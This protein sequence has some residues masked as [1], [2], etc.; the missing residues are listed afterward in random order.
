MSTRK[1]RTQLRLPGQ[2]PG[3]THELTVLRWRGK[4]G[5]PR[6]Y[7]QASIHADEI[8]AM[9]VAH[10]LERKLDALAARGKLLGE[11]ILVPIANPLGLDQ[12]LGGFH[13]GRFHF[14]TGRN[15]NRGYPRTLDAVI[16][17]LGKK[18]LGEDAS[19]NVRAIRK[20]LRAVLSEPGPA[21][22]HGAMKYALYCLAA[23]CD[24]VLDMHCDFEALMHIYTGT[25][26]WPDARDL[27]ACMGARVTLLSG[28]SGGDTFDESCSRIYWQL[29][30]RFPHLPI[31][32]AC[33]AATLE[34]RGD[35]D[36]SDDW[37]EQDAENLIAFFAGRG[38]VDAPAAKA[39]R[40]RA[41][42]TSLEAVDVVVTPA[43]GILV[44]QRDLGAR[45][46]AGE[47]IGEIV[48]PAAQQRFPLVT[49]T[50]GLFFA[51]RGH[52]YVRAGQTVAK[53]AGTEALQWRKSGA[54]LF[55]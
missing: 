30:E 29:A 28:D 40:K 41:E 23:D 45:V 55:D 13:Q 53:I 1:Q 9:L 48:V 42:A 32:P 49:R 16:E 39:S 44:W 6:A 12:V 25:A 15:F 4:A 34:F 22:E 31:P 14:D 17:R 47:V 51:R 7:L 52:R 5:G 43:S 10:H 24:I 54:L 2:N 26:L 33:L 27:S 19:R 35:R 21:D 50:A 3:T 36:V 38:V 11:V 37:A 8:P 46:A 20:A 18:G